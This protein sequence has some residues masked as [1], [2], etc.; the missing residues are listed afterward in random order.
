M[1]STRSARPTCVGFPLGCRVGKALQARTDRPRLAPATRRAEELLVRCRAAKAIVF[2]RFIP[3]ARTVLNPLA[4]ALRIPAATAVVVAVS[5]IPLAR[6]LLRERRQR[7][8][9]PHGDTGRAPRPCRAS[10][11][12]PH[13]R[14]EHDL[15]R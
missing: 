1:L 7:P 3:V 6:E 9:L 12:T 11:R 2:A 14:N 5:L 10:R 13:W 8:G 15:D 4:G